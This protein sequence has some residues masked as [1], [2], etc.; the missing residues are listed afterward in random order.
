MTVDVAVIGGGVSG[1]AAAWELRRQGHEVVVLERQVR[2]GGNAQSTRFGGFLM[3]H[4]P[5]SVTTASPAA[6]ELSHRLG[7]DHLKRDLGDGVRYRYLYGRGTIRRISPHPLGMLFSNYLSPKAR[8]R[9]LAEP[10]VPVKASGEEE[11]V[12]AFMSRRFGAEFASRVMDP[13]VGGLFAG[14]AETLS[15]QAVF[16][17]LVAMESCDGSVMRGALR[18][19]RAGRRMPGRRLFAWADGVATLPRALARSLG[20]A[21][22]TGVAVRRIRQVPGGFRIEAGEAGTLQVPAVVVATQPHVAASLLDPVD[23]DAARALGKI[24]APPLSVVFLGYSRVQVRHP[25]D[26]LGYLTP[27]SEDR[28]LAGALF[29][30]T[31]FSGRA[32]EGHVAL[33]GYVGGERAPELA[34]LPAEELIAMARREFGELLGVRG[35]P[36]V[37]RTQHWPRGLPQYRP[38]HQ[39]RIAGLLAINER[40]PGL[41]LTGNYFQGPGVAACLTQAMQTATCADRYLRDREATCGLQDLEL[42]YSPRTVRLK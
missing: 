10:L 19:R 37:A 38:G 16:P 30:S 12:A 25:L 18:R 7:L 28:A 9:L 15:M 35:S 4:G 8:L 11:T 5:S 1:L 6:A 42:T 39:A 3:E 29:C 34:R 36:V 14:T 41:F 32:P 26:G 31:M 24:D 20:E 13:L 17:S 23:E 22:R 2:P 33:A 21:V 27:S 40:R